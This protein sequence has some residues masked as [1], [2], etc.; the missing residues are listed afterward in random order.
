M[1]VAVGI[2]GLLSVL[3]LVLA[4]SAISARLQRQ[5][6]ETRADALLRALLTSDEY[7]QLRQHDFI[8]VPSRIWPSRRYRVPAAGTPIA[9]YERDEPIA[10]LCLVPTTSLP[11]REVVLAHKLFLEGD[12]RSY[13]RRANVLASQYLGRSGRPALHDSPSLVEETR[14]WSPAT[15]SRPD[16]AGVDVTH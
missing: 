15:R 9:L 8:E 3:L 16:G 2:A 5:G 6:A 1:T 12:E 7:T 13:L 11:G 4:G 10:L 14:S